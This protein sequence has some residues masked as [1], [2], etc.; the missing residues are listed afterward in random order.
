MAT[1]NL[2]PVRFKI[3]STP[4]APPSGFVDVYVDTADLDLKQIDSTGLVIN[5]AAG[6]TSDDP[7]VLFW[8]TRLA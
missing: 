4:S 8:M 1:T 7:D 2:V 3:Q 5:L 6:A